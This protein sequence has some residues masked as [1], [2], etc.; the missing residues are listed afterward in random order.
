MSL[1]VVI[2]NVLP[3]ES[4]EVLDFLRIAADEKLL[5][6]LADDY[7]RSIESGLFYKA[8]I[9]QRTVAVAAVFM[10]SARTP[11]LLEMGSCY[12]APDVR[13]FGLQKLLVRA[14]IASVVALVDPQARIL[15]AITPH[16]LGSRA[17]ILKA[18]FEPLM[19]DARLLTELC[20]Y[21]PSRPGASSDRECCCDFFYIPPRRQRS[22]IAALLEPGPVVVSRA[23]GETMSVEMDMEVLKDPRR[24]AALELFVSHRES[25]AG[26]DA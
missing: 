11:P 18:G 25:H 3:A 13:G 24:R 14:R 22:E 2:Q 26:V 6:R 15:T 9:D 5:P 20:A 16:N 21:C 8:R 1:R 7:R 23:M 10:L 4:E 19:E 17:S 12:V